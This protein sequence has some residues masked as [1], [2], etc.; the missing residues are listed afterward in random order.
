[1][2]AVVYFSTATFFLELCSEDPVSTFAFFHGLKLLIDCFLIPFPHIEAVR[3]NTVLVT[4]QK[5]EDPQHSDE[6]N[7]KSIET[8]L[9]NQD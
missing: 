9:G 4:K 8:L 3:E 2:M 6:E 5:S 7:H 1:M